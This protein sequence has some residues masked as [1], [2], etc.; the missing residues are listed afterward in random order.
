MVTIPPV[1]TVVRGRWIW[2]GERLLERGGL[3]IQDAT[4]AAAL[5]G[6]DPDPR[7]AEVID[8]PRALVHPGLLNAHCHLDL[9]DLGG[10]IRAGLEFSKWLLAVRDLRRSSGVEGLLAA[11]QAGVKALIEAG[12]TAVVDFSHGGHSEAAI[13]GAGIRAAVLREVIGP[14]PDRAAEAVAA[15]G[16]WIASRTPDP[17]ITHGLAPHSPYLATGPLIRHCRR[18]TAGRP[19]SIHA[20][21]LPGE[22]EFLRQGTGELRDFLLDAGMDLAAFSAPGLGPVPY[23]D[24]LGVVEGALLVHGN[25]LERED[26]EVLRGRR[27]AVVFCPRSHRYFDRPAHPL[28]DLL[29]AGI[30]V[31]LGTD[32]AASSRVLSVAEEMREVRRSFPQLSARAIWDLGTGRQLP[33]AGLG[34]PWEPGLLAPGRAADLAAVEMPSAAADPLAAFLG[35]SVACVLT[36][37]GGRRIW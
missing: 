30:P 24:S 34:L 2:T 18:L 21:E 37:V 5:S 25:S 17:L 36:M 22:A 8:L 7:G 10:A 13:R 19:L 27:T 9:S 14:T 3:R 16:G 4:I 15:A 33:A 35:E 11:C 1:E 29:E 12:T 6:D 23:L 26:L 31:A 20:A 32:S 28:P